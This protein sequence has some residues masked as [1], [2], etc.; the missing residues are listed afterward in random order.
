LT[1]SLSVLPVLLIG[2]VAANAALQDIAFPISAIRA[3]EPARS[4]AQVDVEVQLDVP[5]DGEIEV[6]LLTRPAAPSPW[7]M[8]GLVR[9]G[10]SGGRLI[11][12]GHQGVETLLYLRMPGQPGYLLHGPL[13]WPPHPTTFRVAVRWR[14]TVRGQLSDPAAAA[15]AWVGPL[16][17]GPPDTWPACMS[18][19]N[20]AWECIGV[21]LVSPGV[22]V[23]D[24]PSGA[25]FGVA[26]ATKVNNGVEHVASRVAAWGRLIALSTPE[27]GS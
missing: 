25:R 7:R 3:D 2:L 23:H 11:V 14:R 27:A 5:V 19:S 17:D 9:A 16:I 12:S 18:V 8:A 15:P 10:V 26:P 20:T 1:I 24:W 6:A 21:P 22:V 13:R 4:D